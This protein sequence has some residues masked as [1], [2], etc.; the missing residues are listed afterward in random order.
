MD[1]YNRITTTEVILK[2]EKVISEV[3]ALRAYLMCFERE[4]D[5]PLDGYRYGCDV[6]TK[7]FEFEK[8]S[9]K[10]M[11]ERANMNDNK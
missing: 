1:N 7:S 8:N 11:I 2:Y 9:F 4:W 5:V 10:D 6:T 3:R